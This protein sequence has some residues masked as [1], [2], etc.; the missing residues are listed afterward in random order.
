MFFNHSSDKRDLSLKILSLE[1]SII[2]L[3]ISIELFLFK[4]KEIARP[5]KTAHSIAK[6]CPCVILVALLI[7]YISRA[8]LSKY[9]RPING[10]LIAPPLPREPSGYVSRLAISH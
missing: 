7:S 1:C 6:G 5:I 10:D 9:I 2:F 8:S 3:I 4:A